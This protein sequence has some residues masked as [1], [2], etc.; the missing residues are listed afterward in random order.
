MKLKII[1]SIL[2]MLTVISCN[3]VKYEST[4][5]TGEEADAV[6]EESLVEGLGTQDLGDSSCLASSGDPASA[7]QYEVTTK[8][9]GRVKIFAPIGLADGC[10]VPVVHFSNGTGAMCLFYNKVLRHWASHGFIAT[11]Y[12]SSMTGSGQPCIDALDIASKEYPE[13]ADTTRFGSSGHSQGGG[14]SITC[15]YLLEQKYGDNAKVAVHAV[16][17]AHGMS[18]AGYVKEYPTIKS[19]VFMF[20]G[21]RDSIVPMS[22]V[23][24]GYDLLQTETY[25]FQGEGISHLNPQD[26]AAHSGVSWFRWK[27]LNDQ[28]AKEQFLSLPLDTKWSEHKTK[29]I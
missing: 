12:E 13:I 10:K 24:S 6:S 8:T 22:W 28:N 1:T 5:R 20:S 2:L 7:G 27:L 17:P 3:E 11:C 4:K 29:N 9:S 14:A 23:G 26:H 19:P 25:W 21:S 15:A 16:Q 18:R